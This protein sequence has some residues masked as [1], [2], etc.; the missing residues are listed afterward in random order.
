MQAEYSSEKIEKIRKKYQKMVSIVAE[1]EKEFPGRHFTLDGHLIGSIGE[2]M[3]AYH[4]GIK[5]HGSGA[6][7]HDGT[8]GKK[9][10]QIKITQQD[11]VVIS[12]KPDYL[13]VIY[14]T[15]QGDIYEV[16]NGPGTE[17]WET[18]YTRK[19]Y[20]TRYMRVNRL[21]ELDKQVKAKDRIKAK[22]AI[23]K[24]KKEYKNLRNK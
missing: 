24:M 16:Y 22:H 17:P 7:T 8:V 6:E 11:S 23:E 18:A 3:A 21:M 10:V 15:K 5:L 13:I 1:L 2:V 20:K 14:L 9:E 12:G 4:Y 19:G